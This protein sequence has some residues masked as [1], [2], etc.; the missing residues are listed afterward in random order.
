[1]NQINKEIAVK[2]LKL[3][4]SGKIDEAYHKYV[5]MKGKHHNTFFPT[6]FLALREAMKENHEQ[7]P[8]KK[9]EIKNVLSDGE[10]TAVHSHLSFKSGEIGMIVVHLFRFK[11][12]KIV[13]I[14]DC[15]QEIKANSP[16]KDGAF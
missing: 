8:N 3:V 16:N 5:D 1:M 14:W 6:G 4:V 15:G 12:G 11:D 13:E 7:F 9:F 10:L 2:F